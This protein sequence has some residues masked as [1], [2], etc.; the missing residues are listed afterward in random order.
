M[1]SI[2]GTVPMRPRAGRWRAV[3]VALLL[4]SA[5]LG[6]AIAADT[7]PDT[8]AAPGAT[9]V[10]A[11]EF[12]FAP[13]SLT[14]DA[15]STVTW[16]NKDEEPHTVVSDSGLFRSGAIDTDQSFS[17]RFEKPGTYKFFCSIHPRMV[18]TIVVR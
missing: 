17:F 2:S 15:G 8:A 10:V 5:G 3:W 14:I 6:R 9:I 4:A 13:G 7:A 1:S 11:R 12:M 18:G 16:T